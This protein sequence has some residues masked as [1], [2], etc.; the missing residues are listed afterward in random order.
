MKIPEHMNPTREDTN[1]IIQIALRAVKL[2][3]KDF[4]CILMDL[5]ATHLNGCPLDLKRLLDADDFNFI[6]DVGGIA[7]HL[8]RNTGE[9]TDFFWPRTAIPEVAS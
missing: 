5:N 8:D 6:H 2:L 9:L 4:T 3:K 1:I 7:N